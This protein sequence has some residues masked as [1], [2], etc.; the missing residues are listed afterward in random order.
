MNGEYGD[1]PRIQL[2]MKKN[3]KDVTCPHCGASWPWNYQ[4]M[5]L[6]A[7]PFCHKEVEKQ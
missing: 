6:I 3:A 1:K 2:S 5:K 4:T 7:C